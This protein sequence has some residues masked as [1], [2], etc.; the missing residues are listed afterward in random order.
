MK[1]YQNARFIPG[2]RDG[3]PV[4]CNFVYTRLV[5]T[6]TSQLVRGLKG[7]LIPGE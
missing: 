5:R 4:A 3:R 2:F 6:Y 1:E 7:S